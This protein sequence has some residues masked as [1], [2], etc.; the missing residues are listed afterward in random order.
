VI[1]SSL[2]AR[3]GKL[4]HIGRTGLYEHVGCYGSFEVPTF[5]EHCSGSQVK[6]GSPCVEKIGCTG[7]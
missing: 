4:Q 5:Q 7:G 2:N 1:I 6:Q 3:S